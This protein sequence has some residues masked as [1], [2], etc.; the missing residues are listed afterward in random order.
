LTNCPVCLSVDGFGLLREPSTM[1]PKIYFDC[2]VC[3]MF[4]ANMDLVDDDLDA[5]SMTTTRRVRATLSH[6]LRLNQQK[7]ENTLILD[8]DTYQDAA[9]GKLRLPTPAQVALAIIRY[10]GDWV[11]KTGERIESLPPEFPAEIGATSR[12]FAVDLIDQLKT[13]GLVHCIDS[14]TMDSYDAMDLDLTLAGWEAYQSEQAGQQTAGY[15][16]LAMKFGD[17][18]LEALAQ[19]HLKPAIKDLGFELVD[20]RDVAEPGIIDNIMRMR[21][22]DS[23]FV[24]VD[25]THDNSGAYWEAGYAEGLGKPVLYICEQSKFEA[26]RP[27]FDVNHCTTVM[28]T[29]DDPDEFCQLLVA[30]LRRALPVG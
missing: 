3:G 20:M 5:S 17:A 9:N 23:D 13:R 26:S 28:W 16:F 19:D 11:Q 4:G 15:G 30:T 14:S 25:L 18:E 7:S 27:H 22:R 10:I 2:P 29:S 6:W 24:I 12:Q 1:A 8:S 21:I